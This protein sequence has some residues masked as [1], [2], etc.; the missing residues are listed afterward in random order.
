MKIVLEFRVGGK[1]TAV[2]PRMILCIGCRIKNS[3]WK[4]PNV[5]ELAQDRD[6][7]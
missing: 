3:H 7:W 4:Y 1:E 6:A 5:K 2:R